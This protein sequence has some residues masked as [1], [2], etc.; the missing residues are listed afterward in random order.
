M[1]RAISDYDSALPTGLYQHYKGKTYVVYGSVTHS[2]TEEVLVLYA[3]VDQ[4]S[5]ARLWV[6]P[7]AMFCESV[8]TE[9]GP[10]PR[11]L[12]I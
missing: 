1:S 6:R 5:G 2:E 4:P 3:P 10:V 8:E 9:D 11:F 7:L 12:K